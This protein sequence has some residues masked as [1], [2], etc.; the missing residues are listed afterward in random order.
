MAI[1][2]LVSAELFPWN[3]INGTMLPDHVSALNKELK[4]FFDGKVDLVINA[5]ADGSNVTEVTTVF[6]TG[7][8]EKESFVQATVVIGFGGDVT[9][10]AAR[11][12]A[13]S[14]AREH[15]KQFNHIAV[16]VLDPATVP[17]PGA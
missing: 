14:F 9:L 11:E 6:G 8:P 12:L 7:L 4:S 10:D 16:E 3:D 5:D 1:P 17:A 13:A 2:V 15:S